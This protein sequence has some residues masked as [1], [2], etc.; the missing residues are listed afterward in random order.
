MREWGQG[1]EDKGSLVGIGARTG[2]VLWHQGGVAMHHE[3]PLVLLVGIPEAATLEDNECL[4]Q[5]LPMRGGEL[6]GLCGQ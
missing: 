6:C 2:T 1:R 3:A 4:T 5:V